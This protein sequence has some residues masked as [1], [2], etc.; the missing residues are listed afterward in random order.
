MFLD[1]PNLGTALRR[2]RTLIS[3]VLL[4]KVEN[5]KLLAY[6]MTYATFLLPDSPDMTSV[7]E[8]DWK[9]LPRGKLNMTWR[10]NAWNAGSHA[11]S[12]TEYDEGDLPDEGENPPEIDPFFATFGGD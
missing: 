8:L 5:F 4:D 11:S 2:I 6:S 7:L 9:R 3:S 10:V 1:Y 12:E